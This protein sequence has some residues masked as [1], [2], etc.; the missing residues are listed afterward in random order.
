MVA[1]I[2]LRVAVKDALLIPVIS[3]VFN[4]G[5]LMMVIT[6]EIG[7]IKLLP[8][9]PLSSKKTTQLELPTT[10]EILLEVI[11]KT[12]LILCLRAN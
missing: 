3:L 11:M 2:I 1:E 4:P 7:S 9:V 10:L 12:T 6:Q 8:F 5:L